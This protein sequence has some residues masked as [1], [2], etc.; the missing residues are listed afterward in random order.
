MLNADWI[1]PAGRLTFIWLLF[2]P[3]VVLFL[4]ILLEAWRPKSRVRRFWC[5]NAR[6]NVEVTFAGGGV[7]ACSAF[8][9]PEAVTCSR[10]CRNAAYRR[11]WEPALPLWDRPAR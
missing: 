3:S 7:C 5:H 11:Q 9:T 10:A 8:D 1:E 6:R 2:A 4:M